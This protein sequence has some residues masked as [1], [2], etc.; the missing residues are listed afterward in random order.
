[1]IAHY[2]DAQVRVSV[3]HASSDGSLMRLFLGII[4]ALVWTLIMSVPLIL[5]LR[6]RRA[7]ADETRAAQMVVRSG[8]AGG[9]TRRGARGQ[10]GLRTKPRRFKALK[11]TDW[12]AERGVSRR[13]HGWVVADAQVVR[14]AVAI[15]ENDPGVLG[16]HAPN[17]VVAALETG[18]VKITRA[19]VRRQPRTIQVTEDPEPLPRDEAQEHEYVLITL[20]QSVRYGEGVSGEIRIDV[21][22][23]PIEWQKARDNADFRSK[24]V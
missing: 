19:A 11:I 23:N 21:H 2:I 4:F 8:P 6:R 18:W 5:W 3:K 17:S 14:E 1:M 20:P 15:L 12:E 9:A 7:R 16:R 10:H 24:V 13:R 22:G